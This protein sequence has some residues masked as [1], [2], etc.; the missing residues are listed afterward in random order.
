MMDWLTAKLWLIKETG[1]S[2]DAW[3]VMIGVCLQLLVAAFVR[4]GLA[5]PIPWAAV[6][7]VELANEASDL[8]S[9][10]W[11]A[12]PIWPDSAK[13]VAITMALPTLLFLVARFAPRTLLG[14]GG[15]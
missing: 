3:H 12:V 7:A 11:T 9:D 15:R 13:D 4:R 6:L 2:Q 5:S 8:S 1:V 14:R 10:L